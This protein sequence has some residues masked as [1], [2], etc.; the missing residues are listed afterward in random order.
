MAVYFLRHYELLLHNWN[1]DISSKPC[2]KVYIK[3]Y[4]GLSP[5]N[6]SLLWVHTFNQFMVETRIELL[7]G[8]FFR[9]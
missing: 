3:R 4:I 7:Y 8:N 6:K 9:F 1:E 2:Y 5:D